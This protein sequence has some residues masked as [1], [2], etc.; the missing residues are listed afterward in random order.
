MKATVFTK[1]HFN[2]LSQSDRIEYLL[3]KE[4]LIKNIRSSFP[5]IE[6]ISILIVFLF[7]RLYVL[8]LRTFAFTIAN[9]VGMNEVLA[10]IDLSNQITLFANTIIVILVISFITRIL[11]YFIKTK[12][13]NDLN[14]YFIDRLNPQVSDQKH[15]DEVVM[16]FE[17]KRGKRK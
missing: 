9:N 8:N 10:F 13:M 17:K 1:E 4:A 5:F 6:L 2:S 12:Q 11:R 15:N 7:S 14:L 16:N 3:R